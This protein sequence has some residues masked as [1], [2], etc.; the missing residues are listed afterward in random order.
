MVARPAG[1]S[2]VFAAPRLV[3]NVVLIVLAFS[4]VAPTCTSTPFHV[5]PP[6]FTSP[7]SPRNSSFL[8]AIGPVTPALVKLLASWISWKRPPLAR[9]QAA[10]PPPPYCD[11]LSLRWWLS[12]STSCWPGNDAPVSA[13]E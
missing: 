12:G 10:E 8:S 1:P 11:R 5:A 3:L 6:L 2:V 9:H 13:I 4:E 7:S